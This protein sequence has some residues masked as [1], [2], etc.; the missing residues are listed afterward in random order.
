MKNLRGTI[1]IICDTR[2]R[3]RDALLWFLKYDFNA[4]GSK[5]SYVKHKYKT[6]I[7]LIRF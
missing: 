7:L 3:E 2:V 5:K 6:L 4:F 1:L